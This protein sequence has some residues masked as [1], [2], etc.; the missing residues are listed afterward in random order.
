MGHLRHP[1]LSYNFRRAMRIPN[2]CLVFKFD[3]GKVVFIA[4][5]Q[6]DRQT[7]EQ[8]HTVPY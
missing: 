4:D 8:T 7:D 1:K 3:N 2:M 6:I 5:E